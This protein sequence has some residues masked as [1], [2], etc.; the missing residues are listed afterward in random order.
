[1]TLRR[2]G[3]LIGLLIA[4]GCPA[5]A[6]EPATPD[7][8]S[9]ATNLP[10]ISV[11]SPQEPPRAGRNRQQT[12]GGAGG[13]RRTPRTHVT[14]YATTPLSS[15][16]GGKGGDPDK[17]PGTITTVDAGQI[18]RTNS[19]NIADSLQYI[20]GV[21]VSSVSGNEFQPDVQFRGFTGSPVSGTPQGIAVYQNGV[22]VNEAFGDTINWDLIP[23]AAIRS[24]TMVTNNPAFGL[25][26][27]G[28]A[29]N[30]QMKDGFSYHGTQVDVMGGSYGRIQGSLQ[31]GK[32]VDNFA[33]YGALESVHDNGFRMFGASDIKRF[34]GDVG[35]R[36]LDSEIHLNVGAAD[37]KFGAAAT[38]PVELLNT[39]W[40]AV[41]TTPQTSTNQVGYTN[42]T[43]RFDVSPSW[44]IDGNLHFR[45]FNQHTQDGNPTSVQQCAAP[46]LL[47]FGDDL[48]PAYGVNGQQ[49][50]NPFGSALLGEI[51]R[52]STMSTT[53]GTTLQAT[54]TD[55]LFGFDNRFVTGA[56]FDRSVTHFSSSA[57]I[58]TIGTD[59]VV[60]GSGLY[61]G[62]SGDPVSDGP[63]GLRTINQYIG[64]YA[65]DA[66][67]LTSR[68]TV[69]GGGRFNFANVVLQDQFQ[70]NSLLNGNNSYNRFNPV[71]G[72]TYKLTPEVTAYGGYSESS[73]APTPL[74]LGCADPAHPCVLATFL[75]SD[76]PLKQVVSHTFEA[77]FRGH[78]D[79]GADVGKLTW[80][81]GAFRA[82]NT[83]DILSI[84][85]PTL[86]GFGYFANVGS[87]RRQGIEAEARLANKA[88]EV[89]ATYAFVD[90][91]FLDALMLGSNSPSA[92]PATGNIQVLPGDQI[93]AIPRHRIKLGA[94]YAVTDAFKIGADLVYVSSQYFV[95]DE[96]N[97]QPKLPAYAVVN[98]HGSYQIDS[99]YQIY[100]RVDNLFNNHYATYGTFFDTGAV[101][102]F[103]NGGAQF[104]NAQSLSPARPL[105]FYLG[106]KATY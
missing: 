50:T 52:T 20:P 95:G 8:E 79:F 29:L 82:T 45:A 7:R 88:L 31:W 32:Q 92:D 59:Y 5:V 56:S 80:K 48:T 106:L 14:V 42:L 101:P 12:A 74:E 75:V 41:Y 54:N 22:R 15:A 91:R 19:L 68:L 64:L 94:D 84:P 25:N 100:G 3:A 89:Y 21:V 17:V 69:T 23:T 58:G 96:S 77:G 13:V 28:G 37:N 103:S 16:G 71:I 97:Q 85:D 81:L 1:M 18:A 78:H 102:N 55:N 63:V 86:Q 98:L 61:L 47:C 83:N 26:A 40:G 66:I 105:A 10:A 87:T 30:V 90:A 104:A 62:T 51:D 73:R 36:T 9:G 4:S 6:Q 34:Y 11:D 93:P 39:N 2:A 57:E 38:T 27:L 67:D 35:Y 49:L 53:F 99:N 76:P 46:G 33:V 44:T 43:G 65:L 70:A 60:T 72:A 24:V